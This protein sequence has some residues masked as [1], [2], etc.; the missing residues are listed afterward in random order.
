M[1]RLLGK[2]KI[3]EL[4]HYTPITMRAKPRWWCVMEQYNCTAILRLFVEVIKKKPL[5]D[6]SVLV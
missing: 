6:F 5:H 1:L 3:G 2:K 4:E